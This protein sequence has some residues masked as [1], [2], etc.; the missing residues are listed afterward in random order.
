MRDARGLFRYSSREVKP[1][2]LV[3]TNNRRAARLTREK[4]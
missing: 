4:T 2:T 3:W 1:A